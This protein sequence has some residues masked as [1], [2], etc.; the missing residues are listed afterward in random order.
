MSD[1][2]RYGRRKFCK[3]YAELNALRAAIRGH[4]PEATE[5]AWDKCEEWIHAVFIPEPKRSA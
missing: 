2:R 4:D 5:V 3:M 1:D